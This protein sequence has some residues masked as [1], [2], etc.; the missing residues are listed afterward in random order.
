MRERRISYA[1]RIIGIDY[2]TSRV[3][4]TFS[5]A[6]WILLK[7]STL[8]VISPFSMRHGVSARPPAV[9]IPPA[10]ARPAADHG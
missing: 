6:R 4:W 10:S 3:R 9:P 1:S 5:S 8:G 7:I 2:A